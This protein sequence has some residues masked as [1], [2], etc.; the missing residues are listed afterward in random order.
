MN[1][2]ELINKISE[3]LKDSEEAYGEINAVH[4]E[5]DYEDVAERIV[6]KLFIPVVVKPSCD[7]CN[8]SGLIEET[9]EFRTYLCDCDNN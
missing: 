1:K 5:N 6:N 9:N 3:E 4:T 2:K 7:K 8:D